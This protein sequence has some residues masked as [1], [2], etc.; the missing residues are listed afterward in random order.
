MWNGMHRLPF[1]FCQCPF[2][3]SGIYQR[4]YK[5]ALGRSRGVPQ[6]SNQPLSN[7]PLPTMPFDTF[8]TIAIPNDS[9]GTLNGSE[10]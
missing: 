6:L 3:Q 2:Q 4:A 1:D 5:G 8:S 9:L 10:I 7:Q